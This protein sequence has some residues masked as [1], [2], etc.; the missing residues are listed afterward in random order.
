V[1][2]AYLRLSHQRMQVRKNR[3]KRLNVY[4][5]LVKRHKLFSLF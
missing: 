2:K 5:E 4:E 1:K 3:K